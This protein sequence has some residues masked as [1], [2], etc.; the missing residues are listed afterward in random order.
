MLVAGCGLQR[1]GRT[2]NLNGDGAGGGNGNGIRQEMKMRR[3]REYGKY[4][5]KV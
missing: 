3:V 5:V 4:H 2:A 1:C